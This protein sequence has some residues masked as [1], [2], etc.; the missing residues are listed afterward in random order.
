MAI[1]WTG[2]GTVNPFRARLVFNN[3]ERESSEKVF[4][5]R[6]VRKESA[7]QLP[8]RGESQQIKL[9]AGFIIAG[10]ISS[11]ERVYR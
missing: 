1:A 5:I 8:V 9:R 10:I 11:H 7:N 3:G 4:I 6:I 2:V